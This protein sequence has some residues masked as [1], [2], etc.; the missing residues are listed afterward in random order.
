MPRLIPCTG[1]QRLTPRDLTNP[2]HR[3]SLRYRMG[4]HAAFLD[5]MLARLSLFDAASDPGRAGAEAPDDP[6]QLATILRTRLTT[7]DPDDPSLALLD[8]WAAVADVL[9]F[10]QERIANEGFLRTAQ[11]LRSLSELSRLV[12]YEPRPGVAA[13]VHLAFEVDTP[14][15][16]PGLPSQ[17]PS[18]FTPREVLIPRGTA[19]K[20]TPRPGTSQLPQVFET[21]DDLVAR[22]EWNGLRPRLT[23]AMDLR[24]QNLSNI[25]QLYFQGVGLG[26]KPNDMLLIVPE[27][28]DQ[29]PNSNRDSLA[30]VATTDRASP[31][32]FS[33]TSVEE[34]PEAQLTVVEVHNPFSPLSLARVVAPPLLAIADALARNNY[35]PPDEL[36]KLR[37]SLLQL[38]PTP[39]G[40]ARPTCLATLDGNLRLLP[41]TLA[42]PPKA[43]EPLALPVLRAAH[44]ARK[45]IVEAFTKIAPAPESPPSALTAASS[46]VAKAHRVFFETFDTLFRTITDPQ[47][48]SAFDV[49][50]T[51]ANAAHANAAHVLFQI[52]RQDTAAP[53]LFTLRADELAR[54]DKPFEHVAVVRGATSTDPVSIDFAFVVGALAATSAGEPLASVDPSGVQSTL[55][56]LAFPTNENSVEQP[57]Y[58]RIHCASSNGNGVSYAMTRHQHPA[59]AVDPPKGYPLQC[60]F[61]VAPSDSNNDFLRDLEFSTDSGEYQAKKVVVTRLNGTATLATTAT[62]WTLATSPAASASPNTWTFTDN[63]GA[64][65]RGLI[66]SLKMTLPVTD[67]STFQVT[68]HT[69]TEPTSAIL[70]THLPTSRFRLYPQHLLTLLKNTD[71]NSLQEALAQL[72]KGLTS[73]SQQIA[74]L[75]EKAKSA[76][77][78]AQLAG[79]ERLARL[80]DLLHGTKQIIATLTGQQEPAAWIGENPSSLEA[81]RAKLQE[82]V[83]SLT[84]ALSSAP[85][86]LLKALALSELTIPD[87]V[88]SDDK[89]KQLASALDLFV[90]RTLRVKDDL[91]QLLGVYALSA[92]TIRS[93]LAHRTSAITSPLR[94]LLDDDTL[95]V[96][97][98][99]DKVQA[100]RD[101]LKN[102]ADSNACTRDDTDVLAKVGDSAEGLAKAIIPGQSPASDALST[103]QRRLLGFVSRVRAPSQQPELNAGQSIG[104]ELNQAVAD[105]RAALRPGSA[106]TVNDDQIVAL[107]RDK[108]YLL[109]QVASSLTADEGRVLRA[110]LAQ[111]RQGANSPPRVYV[112][113]EQAPLFGWNKPAPFVTEKDGEHCPDT[114]HVSPGPGDNDVETDNRVFLDG[115]H[116]AVVPGSHLLIR[117][118]DGNDQIVEVLQAKV[119]P[120]TQY[121]ISNQCTEVE[122]SPSWWHPTAPLSEGTYHLPNEDAA[123]LEADLKKAHFQ[124]TTEADGSA[125]TIVKISFNSPA[126]QINVLRTSLAFCSPALLP[127]A[128]ATDRETIRDPNSPDPSRA[129]ELDRIALDLSLGQG[130]IVEFA[131][132]Q[133]LPAGDDVQRV[134]ARIEQLTHIGPRYFGDRF[135]TRLVLDRSLPANYSLETVRIYA[136][137]VEATH[138]ETVHEIL[139][140]GD[141]DQAFQAFALKKPPLTYVP[142]R[143]DRGAV[144]DLEVRVND[145]R[146]DR[147]HRLDDPQ[148]APP[149]YTLRHDAD[150]NAKIIFG[151][152]RSGYRLPSGMENVQAL[153]RS[154]IGAAGNAEPGQIDQL[155]NA[156][157]GVRGVTNPLRGDGGADPDGPLDIRDRVPLMSRALDRLISAQDFADF[158]LSFAGVGKASAKLIGTKVFVSV[159]GTTPEALVPD[160]LILRNL[161]EAFQ[162]NGPPEASCEVA[163]AELVFLQIIAK[164][165]ID[166]RYEWRL[167]EPQIRAALLTRFA[168]ERMQLGEDVRLADVF[169]TIEQVPGVIYVDVDTF[170]ARREDNTTEDDSAPRPRVAVHDAFED[171][172]PRPATH[173]ETAPP[174]TQPA[175]TDVGNPVSSA[176]FGSAPAT[177]QPAWVAE[178]C[179]LTPEIPNLLYLTQIP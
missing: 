138:G 123:K 79:A 179:F 46:D 11:H 40:I 5:T 54:A 165:K 118:I 14:P 121:C 68:F 20:S 61:I 17:G 1:V 47:Q 170:R 153:Y 115:G 48:T 45:A 83:Q 74:A 58:V 127:L 105:L 98:W 80:R 169:Q 149:H 10:Y 176:A 136:N 66:N 21:T 59:N 78:D 49:A 37:R 158:A 86:L 15:E 2:P 107:L 8:A 122:V 6:A 142:S 97:A 137:V 57:Y 125:N 93:E 166:P 96:A 159:A 148:Q 76:E 81:V 128:E 29:E 173:R 139:G 62:G 44:E 82:T 168:Y 18:A 114:L 41:C 63:D 32:A 31:E 163:P 174:D 134:F 38:L 73:E 55:A 101:S 13:R 124:V 106:A 116:P 109:P 140:S 152:G 112:F 22:P 72:Q 85:P 36:P 19:V 155:V 156:P 164:V 53:W 108:T 71:V 33:I 34:Q 99:A 171:Q 7:R 24:S 16:I 150:G 23:R 100:L 50:A 3:S 172:Q 91:D 145:V 167:V 56:A 147:R 113:R 69:D 43:N 157:L 103:A 77:T 51:K 39:V 160:S 88:A 12:G 141:G 102:L 143:L 131:G 133:L 28:N 177:L 120:R 67:I 84:S 64:S 130:V 30:P 144:T 26:L 94:R 119:R 151:D 9:A 126:D 90:T 35:M 92:Q 52:A 129:I 111:H 132:R 75:L 178:V 65:A 104:G 162:Q 25:E 161:R 175:G 60:N 154:G 117:Q 87:D 146:W 95:K 27:L 89:K 110:A 70:V 4:T 42:G 135:T